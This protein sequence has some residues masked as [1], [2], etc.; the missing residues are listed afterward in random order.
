M[1]ILLYFMTM[2]RIQNTMSEDEWESFI[3]G[4]VGNRTPVQK[5]YRPRASTYLDRIEN[6]F[7]YPLNPQG[8]VYKQPGSFPLDMVNPQGQLA[9]VMIRI[10][11]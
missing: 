9:V 6:L 10:V 11:S 8:K 1:P 3:G 2:N 4:V 7:I 5:P